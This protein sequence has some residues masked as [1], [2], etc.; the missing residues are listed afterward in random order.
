MTLTGSEPVLPSSDGSV[1]AIA[2]ETD[3]SPENADSG[4]SAVAVNFFGA[5]P[6][7]TD[8]ATPRSTSAPRSRPNVLACLTLFP[9]SS[10]YER[11]RPGF[12][13]R[14]VER[15]PQRKLRR[16]SHRWGATYNA[17]APHTCGLVK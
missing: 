7:A 5:A 8:T 1:C 14:A 2:P 4:V 17:P 11:R 13:Q 15:L 10:P 16:R 9:L 6:P 12:E 3:L